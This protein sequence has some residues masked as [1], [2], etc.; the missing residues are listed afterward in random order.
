MR[1][2]CNAENKQK[3][4]FLRVKIPEDCLVY[5]VKEGSIA[6]DGVSLTIADVEDDVIVCNIIPHT[7]EVTNFSD[8]EQGK[9]LNIEPDVLAKYT[10]TMIEKHI[11]SLQSAG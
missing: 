4:Y 7:Y 2:P 9:I 10:H 11:H 5:I 8:L 3:N 1:L 6:L